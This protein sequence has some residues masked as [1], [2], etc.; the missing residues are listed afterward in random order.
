MATLI[1]ARTAAAALNAIPTSSEKQ[2]AQLHTGNPGSEGKNNVATENTKK[3]FTLPTVTEGEAAAGRKN[4][5]V[6]EWPEVKAAEEY[7]FIS[8]WE[9]GFFVGYMEL[10]E[11]KKVELGNTFKFPIG[12]IVWLP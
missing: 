10:T 1:S 11:P 12:S 4:S 5:T 2:E 3:S 9:F 8:I 7:K 6:A